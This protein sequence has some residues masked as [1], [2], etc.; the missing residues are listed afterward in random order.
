MAD[1]LYG[2]A[3]LRARE[4]A[5]IGKDRLERL[6]NARSLSAAYSML[7]E[8]GVK[9]CRREGSE[10]IA[11][12][13][14]LSGIL[15]DAYATVAELTPDSEA[16][17]LWRYPY[18]CNNIKA[19]IKCAARG[20]DPAPMLFDFGTV[21]LEELR[22]TVVT[23]DFSALPRAMQ[24][25]A[26]TAARVFSETRNPQQVDLILDRACYEDMLRAA[27]DS[28]NAFVKRLVVTKIDLTNALSSIR[29]CRMGG[30]ES[31]MLLLREALLSGGIPCEDWLAAAEKGEAE[32]LSVLR[33]S[34]YAPLAEA[35]GAADGSLARFE[36]L[37]DNLLME[38]L[39]ETKFMPIGLEAM[40][41]FLLA[42]EYEVKNLRILLAAMQAGADAS[43]I[44]ERMRDSYV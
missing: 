24:A 42:H 35:F 3:V 44:R 38:I 30:G 28:G 25:A 9:L 39:K 32:V 22:Q 31:T 23:A 20:V 2:S 19:V 11:R 4:G 8:F 1:Y 12:E 13:E 33:H 27:D 40:V 21:G 26:A 43:T 17:A 37:S 15:R 6:L 36:F 7:S 10:E 41:A 18:D 16:L 29:V 34:D 14:T 5:I